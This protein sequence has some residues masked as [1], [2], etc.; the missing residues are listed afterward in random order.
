MKSLILFAITL[1]ALTSAYA[2]GRPFTIVGSSYPPYSY[3]ENGENKGVNVDIIKAAFAKLKIEPVFKFRPWARA[4]AEVKRG[5]SDAIYSLFKT[6]EREAFLDYPKIPLNYEKTILVVNG[7]STK[8]AKVIED[9]KGWRIGVA[10]KNTYGKTF[11]E[12][13]GIERIESNDSD[14]LVLQLNAKNRMDAIIINELVFDTL[15]NNYVAS[16]KIKTPDFR[17]LEYVPNKAPLYIGFSKN[18]GIK[19]KL[20][21]EKFSD[22]MMQLNKEGVVQEITSR[23]AGSASLHK[24]PDSE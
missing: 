22:A 24:I 9:I 1:F 13:K 4:M 14:R 11:D 20:V 5:E 15:V 17:K 10:V 23:Y 12:Y 7:D 3:L 16:G 2:K 18:S 21:A 19:H 6:K 8:T